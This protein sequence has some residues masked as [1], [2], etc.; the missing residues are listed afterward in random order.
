MDVEIGIGTGIGA[1]FFLR[2]DGSFIG[3]YPLS[4]LRGRARRCRKP[5]SKEEWAG[6]P[7]GL[8][9]ALKTRIP[10]GPCPAG[11]AWDRRHRCSYTFPDLF[12]QPT[13]ILGLRRG[14][15]WR[16]G[17][18]VIVG[19][20][21]W[22]MAKAYLV[23]ANW[24]SEAGAWVAES[25]DI[26]SLVAEAESLNVLMEKIRALAPEPLG[27]NGGL[28]RGQKSAKVIVRA[29]FEQEAAVSVAS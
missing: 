5:E 21:Q 17:A 22:L 3:L 6:N 7:P 1:L 12:S 20:Q 10:S 9:D 18:H 25:G 11:A 4:S 19:Y 26:P 2:F 27:L 28:E 23:T 8:D 13:A 24:D 29:H 16:N 14:A 15:C